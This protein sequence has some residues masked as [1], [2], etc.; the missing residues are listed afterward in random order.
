VKERVNS[1]TWDASEFIPSVAWLGLK[2][3][4]AKV[5]RWEAFSQ[6]VVAFG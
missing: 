2:E 5:A 1:T 4:K 3:A 6:E